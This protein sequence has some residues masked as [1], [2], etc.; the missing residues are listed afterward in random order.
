[1]FESDKGGLKR[2]EESWIFLVCAGIDG[3]IHTLEQHLIA[4]KKDVMI[5]RQRPLLVTKLTGKCLYP[6]DHQ[7]SPYPQ[8]NA[9][10]RM[11]LVSLVCVRVQLAAFYGAEEGCVTGK[12]EA[13]CHSISV[14]E[15]SPLQIVHSPYQQ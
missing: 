5:A 1:M 11:C 14:Q 3:Y 12:V 10:R 7:Q 2:R 9:V 4:R 13:L 15:P 8:S 6:R